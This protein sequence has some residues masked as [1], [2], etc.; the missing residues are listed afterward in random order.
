MPCGILSRG[1]EKRKRDAK[2]DSSLSAFPSHITLN[3]T[4]S[5]NVCGGLWAF[6]LHSTGQFSLPSGVVSSQ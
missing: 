2:K 1:Y 5:V 6:S 3:R 4:H